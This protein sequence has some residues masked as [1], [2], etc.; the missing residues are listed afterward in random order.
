M[1]QGLTLH[2]FEKHCGIIG[3]LQGSE[4]VVFPRHLTG[5]DLINTESR[6]WDVKLMMVQR[7][8]GYLQNAC[9]HFLWSVAFPLP[10]PSQCSLAC[11][12]SV[13]AWAVSCMHRKQVTGTAEDFF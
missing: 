12:R 10:S 3:D 8:E 6:L 5:R 7:Q 2:C 13:L 11:S 9:C 4:P 1:T